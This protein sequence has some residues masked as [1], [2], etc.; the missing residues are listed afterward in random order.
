MSINRNQIR[1]STYSNGVGRVFRKGSFWDRAF[2]AVANLAVLIPGIGVGI[3]TAMKAADN[4]TPERDAGGSGSPDGG[5]GSPSGGG[6][7]GVRIT[8]REYF[9]GVGKLNDGKKVGNT[10]KVF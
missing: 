7:G 9:A 2:K 3:S 8:P 4:L 10:P 6:G 1:Q 5:S